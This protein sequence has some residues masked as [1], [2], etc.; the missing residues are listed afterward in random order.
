MRMIMSTR[1]TMIRKKSSERKISHG[2]NG[3]NFKLLKW[4]MVIYKGNMS[5]TVAMKREQ[6]CKK[7]VG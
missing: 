4:E 5:E 3:L 1:V 7:R 6:R 2:D